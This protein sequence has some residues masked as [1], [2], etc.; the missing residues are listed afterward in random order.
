MI[1]DATAWTTHCSC[2]HQ[3]CRVAM[4]CGFALG[5][6]SAIGHCLHTAADFMHVVI[7]S[8]RIGSSLGEPCPRGCSCPRA[9]QLVACVGT[10]DIL[11]CQLLRNLLRQVR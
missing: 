8:T 5:F 10:D 6:L 2:L 11:G 3:Q 4:C 7:Y 1:S 9:H